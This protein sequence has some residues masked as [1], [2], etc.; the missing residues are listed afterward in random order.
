MSIYILAQIIGFLGYLFY[1]GAPHFRTQTRI[2][3]M[4]TVGHMIL[5]VQW[6]LLMQPSLLILNILVLLTSLSALG[7][8]KHKQFKKYLVLLY[9]VGCFSIIAVSQGTFVDV[10]ALSAFCFTVASKSSQDILIFRK[11]AVISG[12]I[13][14]TAGALALSLP[15]TVFNLMF[16]MGHFNKILGAQKAALRQTS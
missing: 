5:C 9:P 14:I 10:L 7:C 2:M 12:A 15:A 13:L 16:A 3:Q 1:I 4:D 8:Q 6:Y 11:Y